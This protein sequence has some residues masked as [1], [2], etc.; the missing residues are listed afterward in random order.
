MSDKLPNWVAE[1]ISNAKW[2]PIDNFKGS[3]YFLDMNLKEKNVDI[4][5]YEP[6]P[7]GRYIINAD[8]LDT[9]KI[10]KFSKGEVY[11][12]DVKIYKYIISDKIKQFLAEHYQMKM[13]VVYKYE[14]VSVV[15]LN[16]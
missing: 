11:L 2:E 15:D 5:F 7:E 14:L 9:L 4:Q 8:V 16:E 1:E 13:D 6:L 12:F 3:G 10:D